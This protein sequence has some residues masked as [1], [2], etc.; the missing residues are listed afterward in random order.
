MSDTSLT[1]YTPR[2]RAYT[3]VEV[4]LVLFLISVLSATS[5][6]MFGGSRVQGSDALAQSTA[7]AAIDSALSILQSEGTLASVTAARLAMEHPDITFKDS[8]LTSTLSSEASVIVSSGVVAVAVR[9][10]DG[11]CWMARVSLLGDASQ[12]LRVYSISPTGSKRDC[13]AARALET[14]SL[15]AAAGR[16]SS[17]RKPVVWGDQAALLIAEATVLLRAGTLTSSDQVLRNE[18]TA[19]SVLDATLGSSTAVDANDPLLLPYSGIPYVYLPGRA[20]NAVTT[21]HTTTNS[22]TSDIDVRV[23]VA[24]S[25][26]STASTQMFAG[27]WQSSSNLGWMFGYNGTSN[28]LTFSSSSDG[29]TAQ[30]ATASASFSPTNGKAYWLRATKIY[31]TP[32]SGSTTTFYYSPDQGTEPTSWTTVGTAQTLTGQTSSYAS[33]LALTLGGQALGAGSN[34]AGTLYAASVRSGVAGTVVARFD[35][36]ACNATTQT[37]AG[38]NAETWSMLRAGSG[39]ETALVTRTALVFGSSPGAFIRTSTSSV[40]DVPASQS[41][42]VVLAGRVHSTPSSSYLVSR[43]NPASTTTP[44]WAI[45]MTTVANQT[46]SVAASGGATPLTASALNTLAASSSTTFIG[47]FEGVFGRATSWTDALKVTGTGISTPW[48]A[49]TSSLP[50]VVGASATAATPTNFA[51][52]EMYAVAIFTRS[53][54]DTEVARVISELAAS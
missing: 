4:A 50:F 11:S 37:C 25:S 24:L 23:R 17:W 31:N 33:T 26:W 29:T 5:V 30:T 36:A 34:L 22:V 32:V 41:L 38:G 14:S 21:P 43:Y 19:G 53:L 10:D 48:P 18:G 28:R 12:P 9:S 54:S 6:Y 1:R 35:S 42:T 8:P 46:E 7:D 47:R 3:I 51:D 40:L 2:H 27:K 16:G 49:L 44:G 52:M 13:S 15:S 39:V 45:R 20:G